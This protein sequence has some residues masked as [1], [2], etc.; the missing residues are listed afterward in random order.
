MNIE[1]SLDDRASENLSPQAQKALATLT[2]QYAQSLALEASRL[3]ASTHPH[4]GKP[5]ITAK[6]VNDAAIF[7][8]GFPQRTRRAG[9]FVALQVGSALTTL[10]VGTLFDVSP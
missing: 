1:I 9:W 10:L 7:L 4:S 3:E 5:E 6:N 8:R 2:S